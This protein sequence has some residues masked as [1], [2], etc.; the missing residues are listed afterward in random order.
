MP[1]RFENRVLDLSG[2]LRSG[3]SE[4]GRNVRHFTTAENVEFRPYGA[5]QIRKG[6]QYMSD[7]ALTH[8]PHTLA[9]WT[10]SAGV[11][12]KFVFTDGTDGY[13]L[14][15][16]SYLTLTMPHT[17][18]SKQ[19]SWT[20]LDGTLWATEIGG[21]NELFSYRS[22][23]TARTFLSGNLPAPSSVCASS[24]GGIGGNMTPGAAYQYRLRWIHQNGGSQ[25][26]TTGGNLTPLKVAVWPAIASGKTV[27][28]SGN[29]PATTV[30]SSTTAGD[31]SLTMVLN[32]SGTGVQSVTIDGVTYPA[33]QTTS[34]SNI[35]TFAQTKQVLTTIPAGARTDYLYWI[36]E[37][38][39]ANGSVFYFLAQGTSANYTDTLSDSALGFEAQELNYQPLPG[40]R[41]DGIVAMNDR[42]LAWKDST[43]YL[44][45]A[46]G[47]ADGSGLN[48]WNASNAYDFG[49]SDG[50]KITAV[51]KQGDR[52]VVFKQ[53]SV[54]ALE[55]NDLSNYRV[56][57]VFSGVGC[58]G[59]RAAAFMGPVGWFHGSSGLQ[60][61]TNNSI[62]PFGYIEVG[63]VIEKFSKNMYS[64]VVV[65]QHIGQRV[66][67][68]FSRSGTINDTI[69]VYDQRFDTWSVWLGMNCS[70][71]LSPTTVDLGDQESFQ[72]LD[73]TNYATAI[74]DY[75]Y[76]ALLGFYGYGDNKNADGTGGTATTW[77]IQT[78]WMDNGSPDVLKAL[79]QLQVYV[80][81]SGITVGVSIET[82]PVTTTFSGSVVSNLAA[83]LWGDGRLWGDGTLWSTGTA[84]S[85]QSLGIRQGVFGRRYRITFSSSSR[86]GGTIKGFVVDG[87]IQPDRRAS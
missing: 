77:K 74:N 1:R 72:Y 38:T 83:E 49:A 64:E 14:S 20:Q 8:R 24:A 43:V 81:G 55:G 11:S 39:W 13:L 37:R 50:D 80:K 32:A 62:R 33:V 28:A 44:S 18:T 73:P 46:I 26:T 5:V 68:A 29:V 9:E 65:R 85:G 17:L 10:S 52:F 16:G 56:L 2:G 69:L 23:N 42:L 48:N 45:Q 40:S 27:S 15:G 4:Y 57:H 87:I 58:A 7:T 6:T 59:P 84:D 78:P 51:C 71:I 3:V 25:S 70:D 66:I 63:D 61:I 53:N 19:I 30:S 34:G 22:T 76:Y 36:L 12:L 35:L 21:S 86:S 67:M 79:K 75:S 47:T 41:V 54:W 60:R 82:D 31:L